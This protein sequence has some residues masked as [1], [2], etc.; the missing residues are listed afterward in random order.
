MNTVQ[1]NNPWKGLEF[2]TF[3]DSHHFFG[4]DTETEKLAEIVKSNPVTI[5]YGQ[6]GVGKSSLINAGLRPRL[7]E[8]GFFIVYIRSL[9]YSQGCCNIIRQIRS[10]VEAAAVENGIDISPIIEES[11]KELFDSLWCFL[12]FNEFWSQDNFLLTPVIVIDQFEELFTK[13]DDENIPADFLS[14]LDNL[15]SSVPPLSLR[16]KIEAL[17]LSFD[18]QSSLRVLLTLREDFVPRLD[19]YV[20]DL[21][22][23]TMKRCRFSISMMNEEQA[24][25]VIERPIPELLEP[26]VSRVIL[27]S[28]TS[29]H[30]K[31]SGQRRIEPFLLSLFMYRIFRKMEEKKQQRITAD[32]VNTFGPNIVVDYYKESVKNISTRALKYLENCLLT[33]KGY[34]DSVSLD[35]IYESKKV[36]KNEIESLLN[37]RIIKQER[38]NGVERIEFTHDVLSSIAQRNRADRQNKNKNFALYGCGSIVLILLLTFLVGMQLSLQLSTYTIPFIIGS[39]ALCFASLF[40]GRPD[41]K[42]GLCYFGGGFVVGSTFVLTQY[43]YSIT[44]FILGLALFLGLFASFLLVKDCT[45]KRNLVWFYPRMIALW[46]V[47]FLL[48][49]CLGLGY[50]PFSGLNYARVQKNEGSNFYI[51]NSEGKYGLRNRWNVILEPSY[52]QAIEK[53][54]VGYLYTQNGKCGLLNDSLQTI[55]DAIY[56]SVHVE[57]GEL[58]GYIEGKEIFDEDL[59]IQWS[60]NIRPLQ[61]SIIRN[62]LR[63]LV[64]VDGGSFKMGRSKIDQSMKERFINGEEFVHKVQLSDYYI[65]K[66]ETTIE[67]WMVLMNYNPC[68][69]SCPVPSESDYCPVHKISFQQCQSFIKKLCQS[70]GLKFSLPSEAQWEYAAR[71]GASSKNYKYSGGDILTDCGWGIKNS[72]ER[73]HPVGTG[74]FSSNELGLFDMTGNVSEWCLDFMS[75]DFYKK[76]AGSLDPLCQASNLGNKR[77]IRGGAFDTRDE[78]NYRTTARQYADAGQQYSYE[79]VGIRLVVNP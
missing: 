17:N 67:E 70:T 38:I 18:I 34:R 66:Y 47:V 73:I 71:G 43:T 76:S 8:D 21:N 35:K 10:K 77:I 57:N 27:S 45:T 37:T 63:N 16:E 36:A 2:Y 41:F 19:D 53:M 65:S 20:Y 30:N 64:K 79:R 75:T 50:N 15:S 7:S 59:H 31:Y 51:T 6:S 58:F 55:S 24:L 44:A 56:D 25:S 49:P 52:D 32:L 5:L 68:D 48:L 22:L 42:R 69:Q 4:R 74:H 28:L 60:D 62:I 26:G 1:L 78:N 3:E 29:H 33:S 39:G 40:G 23:E 9:D 12:R 11:G 54:P 46:L 72:E 13:T 14:E 61:K